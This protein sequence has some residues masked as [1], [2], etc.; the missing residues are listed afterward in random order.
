MHSQ[1]DDPKPLMGKLAF[2][3]RRTLAFVPHSPERVQGQTQIRRRL[4]TSRR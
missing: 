3:K 2:G 4:A 1:S